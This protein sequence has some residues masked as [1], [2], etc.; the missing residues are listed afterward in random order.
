MHTYVRFS[1]NH[2]RASSMSCHNTH[3]R[4]ICPCHMHIHTL[5]LFTHILPPFLLRTHTHTNSRIHTRILK[6][7]Q[8]Q[9]HFGTYTKLQTDMLQHLALDCALCMSL[10]CAHARGFSSLTNTRSQCSLFLALFSV[11]LF[12]SRVFLLLS[13]SRACAHPLSLSQTRTHI[14]AGPDK[15]SPF[16][17]GHSL[18]Q[19]ATVETCVALN[20]FNA[21]R[22]RRRF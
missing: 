7:M 9:R 4:T 21:R 12:R 2:H 22:C 14:P 17:F 18:G 5:S 16:I 10:C 19:D 11:S 20:P 13:L 6:H 3:T 1:V 8:H 15:K